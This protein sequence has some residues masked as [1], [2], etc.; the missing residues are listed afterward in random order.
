MPKNRPDKR[1]QNRRYKAEQEE[2]PLGCK[3]AIKTRGGGGVTSVSVRQVFGHVEK[4]FQNTSH[5]EERNNTMRTQQRRL[6]RKGSGFS[7]T[8]GTD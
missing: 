8:L 4:E 1:E 7:K 5:A 6:V 2:Q 3:A